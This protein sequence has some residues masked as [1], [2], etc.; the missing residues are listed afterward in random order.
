MA[1]TKTLLGL[2][3]VAAFIQKP[4]SAELLTTAGL[5][6]F[7]TILGVEY[8]LLFAYYIFIYPYYFSP[9]RHVPGPRNNNP[10]FGHLLSQILSP[11]PNE[12]FLTW[13]RS[14]LKTSFPVN[15]NGPPPFIRYFGPLG[16]ECLLIN[17]TE[18][19]NEVFV[20]HPYAFVKPVF[21]KKFI[22]PVIGMKGLFF[23]EGQEE[24]L[25]IRRK[26][27]K[28]FGIANLKRLVGVFQEKAA[29]LGDVLEERIDEFQSRAG[30]D[31]AVIDVASEYMSATLDIIGV[32]ALGVE[33]GSL[34]SNTPFKQCFR[35]VFDPSPLGAL[36][37]GL[38]TIIPIRWL[39]FKENRLFLEATRT[40]RDLTAGIIRDRRRDMWLER[41]GLREKVERRDLL[42]FMLED[43]IETPGQHWDEEELLGHM[44]N[45]LAA[46][47]ETTATA[48]TWATHALALYPDVQDDLRK[49]VKEMLKEHADPGYTELE[50]MKL[51]NRFCKEV[52]RFHTPSI[53]APRTTTVPIVICNTL[54]PAGTTVNL[55]SATI[56]RN[57]Q[58]WGAD[59]NT[60]RP[61]RW[62]EGKADDGHRLDSLALATF[63]FGPRVCIGRTF[64][65]LEMKAILVGMLSRFEFRPADGVTCDGDIKLANP[66]PVLRAAGGLKVKVRK[67]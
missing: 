27:S 37:W 47:H 50:G 23:I 5:K 22:G 30:K 2:A 58:I 29:E 34:A 59:A 54:I 61:S 14:S 11:D 43:E 53:S 48:L 32:A 19:I 1:S 38:D 7:V 16:S 31:D 64:A 25:A 33:L 42:T 56:H 20:K 51:L 65:I 10:L 6:L 67:I 63:I 24:H 66:S 45:F 35:H 55:I 57:T 41:D 13:M 9:L 49:E 26:M 8:S 36:L 62:E 39:P 15:G 60:F 3:I 46:G 18:A 40:I 28:T 21:M 17:S 12:P 52:F 4:S 44:L